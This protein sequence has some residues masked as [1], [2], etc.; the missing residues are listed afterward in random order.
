M[1][2]PNARIPA[3]AAVSRDVLTIATPDGVQLPAVL[4]YPST[5]FN[6][7]SPGIVHIADGP[8]VSLLRNA[9]APRFLAD[10]LAA[11][12]Y[13]NLS[14]ETRLTERYAFSRFD[15]GLTDI[16]AAI[17]GLAARGV[18]RV[19]L[20][21]TGL[22][23]ILAGRYAE[24]AGDGRVR[25]LILLSPGEDLG[26]ALRAKVGNEKYGAMIA[27][28]NK[29]IDEG[30]RTF[31][32]LG[33]GMI[34]TPPTFLDWYGPSGGA[35]LTSSLG[36]I[37]LPIMLVAG[38]ADP[39]VGADRIAK[40]K[41]AAFLSKSVT[42]N[43][44]PNVAHDLSAAAT[45]VLNDVAKWMADIGLPSPPQ[46]KTQVLDVK[47][48]DGIVLSGV[49]YTPAVTPPGTRPAF[50]LMHGWT[51][52]VMRST[53]HWL[54]A[55]LAQRGYPVLAMRHRGSGFRGTVTGKFE[56]VPG[57]IAVWVDLMAARGYAKLVGI[58]HSIGNLWLSEYLSVT[59]DTRLKGLVYLAPQRDL[60]KHA[61]VAMGEDLYART[62]LD[63]EEAVRD[64]KGSTH[65]IDAPFPRAVY[66]DDDRQPMFISSPSSGFT[67]YYA[68]AF[69]SYWG[70]QSKAVHSQLIKDVK[71]PL[72]AL[73]GSRDPF[74]QGA[75]LIEFTAAAGSTAQFIF[76]GGPNGA[77]HSFEGFEARVTDD[78]L[79]WVAKTL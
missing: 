28:A 67:Y 70:P 7:A 52:D 63:A 19:I 21:G 46:I 69:L 68:D 59:K 66:E 25:G 51:S 39:A 8:G 29:A 75:Y 12:G 16:K 40:L 41:A 60:P 61:R 5:G 17:D 36:N 45:P 65:L 34:F 49:L 73:G 15:E 9:D 30:D 37:D 3:A 26:A 14:L 47:T 48:S 57:D 31:V 50:L 62:V 79:A 18:S 72:L 13:G 27:A 2:A 32:D 4:S 10:G 44:Y 71:V 42:V 53:S 43:T 78:I 54:A 33:D 35:S 64:G 38:G 6:A 58:G 24:Q 1:P 23:A 76:Y 77:P 20:S 22:G 56:E 74:M 55:R 11:R